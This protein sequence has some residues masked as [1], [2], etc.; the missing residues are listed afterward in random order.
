[1]NGLSTLLI[2]SLNNHQLNISLAWWGWVGMGAFISQ[3]MTVLI[4]TLKMVYETL[5]LVS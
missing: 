4:T 1:M 2:F 3:L 5:P